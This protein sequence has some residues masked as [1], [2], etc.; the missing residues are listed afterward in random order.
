M[1]FLLFINK[2]LCY[3]IGMVG[4]K[5][6]IKEMIREKMNNPIYV[7]DDIEVTSTVLDNVTATIQNIMENSG[8]SFEEAFNEFNNSEF[9]AEFQDI[10]NGLWLTRKENFINS[11]YEYSKAKSK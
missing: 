10:D 3:H 1:Q 6:N 8:K 4:D 7:I 5:V 2:K 11:Y 9:F